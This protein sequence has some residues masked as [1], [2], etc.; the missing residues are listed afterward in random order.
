MQWRFHWLHFLEPRCT[1]DHADTRGN[2]AD[3]ALR[4]EFGLPAAASP[5]S[6]QGLG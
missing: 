5:G 2:R 3:R 4:N 1:Y 6:G